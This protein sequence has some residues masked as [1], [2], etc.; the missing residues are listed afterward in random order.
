MCTDVS[1]KLHTFKGYIQELEKCVRLENEEVVRHLDH[2]NSLLNKAVLTCKA[3]LATP[4]SPL[5]AK[6]LE[7]KE[8]IAP[9]QNLQQQPR[10]K[11]FSK[12]TLTPGRKRNG[13]VL[14]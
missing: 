2:I 8:Y 11:G 1:A 4:T 12:T 13:L 6:L 9:G 10:G 3:S 5:P 14:R 7:T